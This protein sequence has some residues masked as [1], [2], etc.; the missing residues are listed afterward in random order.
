MAESDREKR[1]QRLKGR[2]KRGWNQMPHSFR[3][4]AAR[5]ETMVRIE[6]LKQERKRLRMAYNRRLIVI[7]R[8]IRSLENLLLRDTTFPE[9]K[10]PEGDQDLDG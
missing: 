4:V 2:Y 8:Q 6:M 1:L 9:M 10:K 7:N 3:R 5:S